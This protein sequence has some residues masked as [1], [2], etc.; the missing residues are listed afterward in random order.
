MHNIR[1]VSWHE[2]LWNQSDGFAPRRHQDRSSILNTFYCMIIKTSVFEMGTLHRVSLTPRKTII[3]LLLICEK[4]PDVLLEAKLS[5]DASEQT[6]I[7][8][9]NLSIKQRLQN[10][11]TICYPLISI[12][13]PNLGEVVSVRG[14]QRW[15]Y[16]H[17]C[18]CVAQWWHT[19]SSFIFVTVTE[20]QHKLWSKFYFGAKKVYLRSKDHRSLFSN[21]Q[22]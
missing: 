12:D 7:W 22:K 9:W 8:E 20:C 3:T 15:A 17:T 21:P 13:Q 11:T 4:G 18:M 19:L 1:F 6:S 2:I 14:G 5:C 10:I 16:M